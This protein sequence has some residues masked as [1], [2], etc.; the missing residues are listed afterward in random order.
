MQKISQQIKHH[1]TFRKMHLLHDINNFEH[2]VR[3]VYAET[4]TD[5]SP[6]NV[7]PKSTGI[8]IDKVGSEVRGIVKLVVSKGLYCEKG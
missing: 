3:T 6:K 1:W 7:R 8:R 4:I 2:N 5:Y